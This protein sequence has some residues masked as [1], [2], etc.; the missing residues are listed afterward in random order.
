MKQKFF[1][2]VS[3]VL[4][5]IPGRAA[6]VDESSAR[7]IVQDFIV[8]KRGVSPNSVPTAG[9]NTVQLLYAE[10]SSVSV[11][12]NAYYI[13]ST[14]DGFVIVAGDDRAEQI[15]GY[16]DGDFDMNNIP[17]GL[18]AMLNIYKEQIDYLLEHPGLKVEKPSIKTPMLR[19]TSVEPLLKAEWDQTDPYYNQCPVYNGRP[20]VTGCACTSLC[21]VMYYWKYPTS[22]TPS[23]PSYTTYKHQITLPQLPST[24]FDWDNMIDSYYWDFEPIYTTV[25]G[26]AVAKLM[27]YVG[28]AE[29]MDY[30]P[31]GSAAYDLDILRAAKFF[32]YN[33][34]AD[35]ICEWDW[36][37]D[38]WTG[39][40]SSELYYY[41]RPV[42]Y[43]A[44]DDNSN[45]GHSFVIDGY[46]TNNEYN[47]SYHINWG[48]GGACNG[49][50]AF[51]AFNI[52]GL[53]FNSYQTMIYNL[54]PDTDTSPGIVLDPEDLT[55]RV[56]TG[57]S[58]IAS[59]N[60]EGYYLTGDLTLKLNDGDGAFSI[61]KTRITK[62]E[63]FNGARVTVTYSPSTGGSNFAT[64][65]IS[66]GGAKEKVV[67]LIGSAEDPVIIVEPQ[68]LSF[69]AITGETKTATFKVS[70]YALNDEGN[71]TLA[72][73]NGN[74]YDSGFKINRS[75]IWRYDAQNGGVDVRVEYNPREAGT[76]SANIT[77]SGCG[78]EPRTVSLKGTATKPEINVTPSSLSFVANI[79]ESIRQTF[80]VMSPNA[81]GDIKLK[82]L[83]AGS[84][85]SI[86]KTLIT[87]SEALNSATVTVEYNPTAPGSKN[88]SVEISGGC[89]YSIGAAE[90]KTVNISGTAIEPQ[91]TV[92][93][94][95]LS[96]NTYAGKSVSHTFNITGFVNS[97]LALTL[98]DDSGSYSIDKTIIT[99]SEVAGSASVTVTY[100]PTV[101]E[102]HNA[103]VTI[104]GGGAEAKT[105]FLEGNIIAP[106]IINTNVSDLQFGSAYTGYESA[107]G[108]TITCDNLIDNLQ[109][110]ISHDYGN[111]Y[112]LSDWTITPEAAAA[113][114][115]VI[116]YFTPTSGGNKTA[117]LNIRGDGLE[118]VR[119]P[120]NGTG[121]KSDGYIFAWP[122]NLSFETLEG[123][124]VTQTFKVTYTY[125]NGSVM[126]SSVGGGDETAFGTEG[127]NE[128]V[129]PTLNASSHFSDLTR[130]KIPFD[131]I[132]W[133]PKVIIDSLPL[134]LVKSL[135]LEL[136]GDDCFDISP[137]R[138]RLSSVPCSEYV[139]VTYYP[140]CVGEHDGNI[141]IWLFGGSARPFILP[142]HGTATAQ[143][144]YDNEGNGLMITQNES[145][146]NT[147]VNEMLMSPKVYADGQ[148]IIIETPVAQDA[149]VSDIAGHAQKIQ[150]TVGSN[151]IPVNASG[152]YIIRIREKTTKLIL[153]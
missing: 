148:N 52:I 113:G 144:N 53:E 143:F 134:V 54:E 3:L 28:Q 76:T 64:V 15:L 79:G 94:E 70:G 115:N 106:P 55:F 121:I 45:V 100:N 26:N 10:M 102:S 104:S 20:C 39:I 73:D 112:G 108:I 5:A 77:I 145:S 80:T 111:S 25:Q 34:Y 22:A 6:P 72:F 48:W 51:H 122:T 57:E 109:L 99:P 19:G 153:K 7:A 90:T 150:L 147:I 18:Q 119:I 107:R 87:K 140:D 82:L 47:V 132:I 75:I 117:I 141:K 98:N 128:S 84:C 49:Y 27:R 138:I 69:N 129:P 17:C 40:I 1:L 60:V 114:S 71:L 8:E 44:C 33:R 24:T 37:E 139:T 96:F 120:L 86:D 4:L 32:G 36:D 11:T 85:F 56:V 149:I 142:I 97:D 31:G 35:L 130:V 74:I 83:N 67:T 105:V 127:S 101:D 110:S 23:V 89:Y 29:K 146:I 46:K 103:S 137:K 68:S 91:F 66:G 88:A 63:A 13:Y 93:P 78:A 16:G 14:G 136:T 92:S 118:T 95:I 43:G 116:V 133:R 81:T 62:S 42:I 124:P 21:Q 30:S 59:F 135:V 131:S 41:H 50:F 2:L 65:T 152:V 12:Q 125:P 151:E 123:I 126:I 38:L 61:N 9:G 58:A